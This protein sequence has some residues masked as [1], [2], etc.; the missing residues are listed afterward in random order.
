MTG[1]VQ[2]EGCYRVGVSD[3]PWM[4]LDLGTDGAVFGVSLKSDTPTSE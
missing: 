1:D 2:G 3:Q 4:V